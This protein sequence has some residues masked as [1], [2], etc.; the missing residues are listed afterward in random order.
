MKLEANGVRICAGC[1]DKI[2][3]EASLVAI[4]GEIDTGVELLIPNPSILRHVGTPLGWIVATDIVAPGSG[5]FDACRSS[6]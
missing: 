3:L 2:V 5:G 4:E 6:E 1:D